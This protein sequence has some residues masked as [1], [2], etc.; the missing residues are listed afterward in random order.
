MSLVLTERCRRAL[1]VAVLL[2][3]ISCGD[4]PT[5]S[6]AED[7]VALL[8]DA[9]PHV[10]RKLKVLSFETSDG[11]GQTVHPDF[12]QMTSWPSPFLLALTPY[13]YG[14]ST[15]ENPSLYARTP[16]FGWAPLP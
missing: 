12:A 16:D 2:A 3:P 4:A 10:E 15:E 1:L 13:P 8:A 11:S 6:I 9:E 5:E 14:S 7:D